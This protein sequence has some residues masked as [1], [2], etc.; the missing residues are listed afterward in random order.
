MT[1]GVGDA[2]TVGVALASGV[3]DVVGGSGTAVVGV[4][5]GVGVS[6]ATGWTVRRDR[7]HIAASAIASTTTAPPS[8]R[9]SVFL[10]L[11]ALRRSRCRD[12]RHRD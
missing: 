8:T 2:L 12:R 9:L 10:L 6:V 1:S 3:G 5:V 4:A 11:A 7:I